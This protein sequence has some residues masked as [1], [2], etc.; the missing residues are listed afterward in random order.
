MAP[1][2]FNFKPTDYGGDYTDIYTVK[3]GG[4]G[5]GGKG[6]GGG[7]GGKGGDGRGQGGGNFNTGGGDDNL[8]WKDKGRGPNRFQGDYDNRGGGGG[9]PQKAS[10]ILEELMRAT[11]PGQAPNNMTKPNQNG[12]MAGRGGRGVGA[13]RFAGMLGPGADRD[14][15]GMPRGEPAPVA[16]DQMARADAPPPGGAAPGPDMKAYQRA[17]PNVPAAMLARAQAGRELSQGGFDMARQ[18]YNEQNPGAGG[19]MQRGMD[20]VNNRV[21]AG[22]RGNDMGPVLDVDTYGSQDNFMGPNDLNA[23]NILDKMKAGEIPWPQGY[24]PPPPAPPGPPVPQ[25][26]MRV[27]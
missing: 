11:F 9:R 23:Q 14:E 10:D 4:G 24:T 22:Y 17:N 13:Q 1:I 6:G 26:K 18:M 15:W 12:S 3:G 5:G 16:R 19:R 20:V 21:G 7:G 25:N 2:K 27:R 8:K